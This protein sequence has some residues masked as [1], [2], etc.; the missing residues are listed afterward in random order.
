MIGLS[1]RPQRRAGEV[2]PGSGCWKRYSGRLWIEVLIDTPGHDCVVQGAAPTRRMADDWWRAL[3]LNHDPKR[4]QHILRGAP[5]SS[6]R[7]GEIA[8][9]NA[10]LIRRIGAIESCLF[11]RGA[12][13]PAEF[14]RWHRPMLHKWVKV[15]IRRFR[16]GLES[17]PN[18][19]YLDGGQRAPSGHSGLRA[20]TG[21]A[22]S[23]KFAVLRSC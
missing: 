22:R 5:N 21:V 3:T 20:Y 2:I 1:D 4:S 16:L 12:K 18:R 7:H 23:A 6:K 11:Q 8:H 9:G 15:E 10:Q 17:R 13:R 14:D 19:R